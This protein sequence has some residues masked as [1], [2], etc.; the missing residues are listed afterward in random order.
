LTQFGLLE[1]D[2]KL[3]AVEAVINAS[4]RGG[5]LLAIEGPP[6]IG[7]TSLL[8]AAKA[9]GQAAGMRVLAARGSELERAFS[10]GVVRQLFESFLA[11]LPPDERAGALAGAGALA[12]PLFDPVQLTAAAQPLADS[13]LATLHGLYWLAAN[14]AA[15]RPLL[16]AVDDLHWCDLP[17]LRWL[18]YV[19]PRMEGLGLWIAVSLRHEDPGEDPSLLAQIVSDPLATV[20][21]PAPLSIGAAARFV[22]GILSPASRRPPP[23]SRSTPSPRRSC[24]SSA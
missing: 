9:R 17:S 4:P 24:S 1:R 14:V 11:F 12:A 19:L 20:I 22:R 6:G 13:S 2:A 23:P 7:K 8:T 10:Y 21:R 15:S 18:A 3:A 5:R 16:L